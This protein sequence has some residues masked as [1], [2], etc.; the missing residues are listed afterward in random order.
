MKNFRKKKPP[1]VLHGYYGAWAPDGH[2]G[3]GRLSTYSLGVFEIVP[4]ASGK[5]WK[6]STTV[7]RV[8]T[9]PDRDHPSAALKTAELV[10]RVLEAGIKLPRKTYD[11]GATSDG[12]LRDLLRNASN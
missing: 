7:C 9:R 5:G 1:E 8:V 12:L 6:R 3:V 2:W 10:C 4:K 11:A